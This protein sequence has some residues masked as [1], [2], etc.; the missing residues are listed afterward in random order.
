M[1]LGKIGRFLRGSNCM[2][3]SLESQIIYVTYNQTVSFC[4]STILETAYWPL[5]PSFPFSSCQ[6]PIFHMGGLVKSK[7]S[8]VKTIRG[9]NATE[10]WFDSFVC[11]ASISCFCNLHII[12][13]IINK[14]SIQHVYNVQLVLNYDIIFFVMI[15]S[16]QPEYFSYGDTEPYK[17]QFIDKNISEHS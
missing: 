14:W 9:Q 2:N 16:L 7:S 3:D 15:F 5:L 12:Q 13:K 1:F 10:V 17:T 8:L 4:S 6:L 11:P